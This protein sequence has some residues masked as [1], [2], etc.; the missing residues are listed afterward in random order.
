MEGGVV[1]WFFFCLYVEN[2]FEDFVPAIEKFGGRFIVWEI[3]VLIVCN[4]CG[5]VVGTQP[6]LSASQLHDRKTRSMSS[7]SREPA[8]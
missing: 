7:I 4:G 1:A 3:G 2:A 6:A 5:P 8:S